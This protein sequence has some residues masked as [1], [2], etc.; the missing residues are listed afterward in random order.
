MSCGLPPVCLPL[1]SG[2]P[3]GMITAFL[4]MAIGA[5]VVVGSLCW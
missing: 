4:A 1:V 3:A 5:F 2:P